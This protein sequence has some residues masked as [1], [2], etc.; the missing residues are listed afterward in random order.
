[1]TVETFSN[2]FLLA[3]FGFTM[4]NLGQCYTISQS[5]KRGLD[6]R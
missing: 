3:C 2:L 5:I 4:F 6:R 1:M